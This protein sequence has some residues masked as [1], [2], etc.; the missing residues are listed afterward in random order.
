MSAHLERAQLLLQQ[1]R[2][3]DAEREAL[4][5]LT[6]APDQPLAHAYLALSRSDQNRPLE[7]IDSAR[8]AVGF[9]PDS[10]FFHYVYAI[11][12]HRADREAEARNEINEAI[13]I[14]P[15]TASHFSLLASI[16][17]AE[18]RWPAGLEGGERGVA[19]DP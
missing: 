14:D 7:A 10:A 6:V 13:R 18:R 1:S 12:L 2:P 17:L 15:E 8:T 9:A 19:L 16:E 4:L 5:A 11:V 3:A